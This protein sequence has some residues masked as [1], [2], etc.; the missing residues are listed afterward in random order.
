MRLS[1]TSTQKISLNPPNLRPA[2]RGPRSSSSS[3]NL[4]H[5]HPTKKSALI[6]SIR[7]TCACL[8]PGRFHFNLI[9]L[10]LA[11]PQKIRDRLRLSNT[12]NKIISLNLSKSAPRPA[13]SAFLLTQPSPPASQLHHSHKHN[14]T[15]PATLRPR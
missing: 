12:H 13:G 11:I 9:S 8:P 7:S 15:Q 4:H 3:F 6:H 5:L 1:I 2:P 10:T 14:I